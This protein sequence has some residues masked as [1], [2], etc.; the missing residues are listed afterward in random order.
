M[1]YGEIK[2]NDI[3][4][5]EGVRVSLFVSGC[6]N[7]CPGCFNRETWDFQYGQEFT[8][9]TEELVLTA[10]EPPHVS[11]LTVLG[12]E[13]FEPE[14]QQVL[15]AFLQRV[16]LLFPQKDIWC[17][18]GCILERD[19]LS[20]QGRCHTAYT[21]QLLS[22]IDVLVDGPFVESEKEVGLQFRGSRNQ[23]ILRHPLYGGGKVLG[24]DLNAVFTK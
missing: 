2:R 20:V 21:E 3:A 18:T 14:N 4:N 9:A 17:F 6:R 5:G 24:S 23:R 13:P 7:C 22:C 11:G 10:L 12:G 19:I 8:A 1:Y 15:A 16:K